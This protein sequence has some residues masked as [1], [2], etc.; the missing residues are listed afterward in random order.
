MEDYWRTKNHNFKSL[1][2]KK[3]I[4][5][6]APSFVPTVVPYFS[7]LWKTT[8]P[9]LPRCAPVLKNSWRRHISG[10]VTPAWC[11]LHPHAPLRSCRRPRQSHRDH[12]DKLLQQLRSMHHRRR[13]S[14][15]APTAS[16]SARDGSKT[17]ELCN[18]LILLDH[19]KIN[20]V[21]NFYAL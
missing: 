1:C 10:D 21:L 9:S 19:N 4:F 5:S 12:A 14:R 20:L 6:H 2:V 18:R 17:S 11:E 7:I 13:T 15:N 8:S 3:L 16:T